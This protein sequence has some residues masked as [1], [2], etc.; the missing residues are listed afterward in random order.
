[1][2]CKSFH[3]IKN[4]LEKCMS[5]KKMDNLVMEGEKFIETIQS[6]DFHK[7]SLENEYSDRGSNIDENDYLSDEE[8]NNNYAF[9]QKPKKKTNNN[10]YKEQFKI[11]TKKNKELEEEQYLSD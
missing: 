3:F 10:Q 9:L 6:E 2:L 5:V 7:L 8:L 11:P 1:M 4:I